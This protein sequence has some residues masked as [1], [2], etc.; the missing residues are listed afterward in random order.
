MAKIRLKKSIKTLKELKDF[1]KNSYRFVGNSYKH[2]P[3]ATVGVVV[4]VTI[5]LLSEIP[6]TFDANE[7]K[8]LVALRGSTNDLDDNANVEEIS[9]Y[10]KE[11][12]PDQLKGLVSSIT[13]KYHEFR[14]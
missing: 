12:N 3:N 2:V 11:L 1:L 7:E 10:L 13:G 5:K 4:A 9:K 8:V 6:T 14:Y